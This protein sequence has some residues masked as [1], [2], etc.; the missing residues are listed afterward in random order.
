MDATKL[1]LDYRF[2]NFC[3]EDNDN[4]FYVEGKFKEI[5]E[6]QRINNNQEGAIDASIDS[7]K[8]EDQQHFLTYLF[9][10]VKSWWNNYGYDKGK[11]ITSSLELFGIVWFIN[12]ILFR[13]ILDI[14]TYGEISKEQKG[15]SRFRSKVKRQL[16]LSLLCLIYSGY[17]FFGLKFEINKLKLK[18]LWLAFWV[19]GQYVVGII[20]LAYI[21]NLVITR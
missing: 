5:I 11:V 17:L 8:F 3:Y 14:Y 9:I 4:Y 18:S 6:S 10:P 7:A 15:S 1:D 21:A 12:L 19:I 13:K 20:C 2:F 16:Y